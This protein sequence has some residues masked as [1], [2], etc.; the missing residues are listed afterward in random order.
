MMAPLGLVHS[1]SDVRKDVLSYQA[2]GTMNDLRFY[3]QSAINLCLEFQFYHS[4]RKP[5][6]QKCSMRVG[7]QLSD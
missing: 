6:A 1:P 4:T 2:N 3:E 5:V 7:Q